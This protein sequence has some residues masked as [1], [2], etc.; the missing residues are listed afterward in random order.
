MYCSSCMGK[1][2]LGTLLQDIQN[3]VKNHLHCKS[4]KG[5]YTDLEPPQG[6]IVEINPIDVLCLHFMKMDPS[7]NGKEN[8]IVM[9]DAF[10]T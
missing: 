5:Q 4:A 10:F 2:S 9:M 3:W 7:M 8:I 1:I 6:T